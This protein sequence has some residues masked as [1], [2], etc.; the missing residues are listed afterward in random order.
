MFDNVLL[1]AHTVQG[2]SYGRNVLG[3]IWGRGTELPC[4]LWVCHPSSTSMYSPTQLLSEPCHLGGG[5]IL[6]WFPYVGMVD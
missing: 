1:T 5:V 2:N 6:W 4:P 3:R